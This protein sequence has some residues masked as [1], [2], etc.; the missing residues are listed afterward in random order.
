MAGKQV[1][2]EVKGEFSKGNAPL[3]D[4][5]E[6]STEV[7]VDLTEYPEVQRNDQDTAMHVLAP[8][9]VPVN[10]RERGRDL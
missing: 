7:I 10:L 6:L 4:L 1:A 2:P 3:Q 9:C 5:Q 8:K